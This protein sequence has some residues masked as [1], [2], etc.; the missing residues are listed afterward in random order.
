MHDILEQCSF[1]NLKKL[2]VNKSGEVTASNLRFQNHTFFGTGEVGDW[3]RHLTD[4]MADSLNKL[5]EQKLAGS[6]LTFDDDSE[7]S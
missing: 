5:I 6:G 2:E 3:R 7:A 1:K 4:K